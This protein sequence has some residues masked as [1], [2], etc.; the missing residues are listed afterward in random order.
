MHL[1]KNLLCIIRIHIARKV[2]KKDPIVVKAVVTNV[3]FYANFLK[4]LPLT[5][6]DTVLEIAK[7]SELQPA[8]LTVDGDNVAN[9][10]LKYF[11]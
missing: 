8:D 5:E 10:I 6:A 2:I 3:Q 11:G 9:E 1:A 4:L 7:E